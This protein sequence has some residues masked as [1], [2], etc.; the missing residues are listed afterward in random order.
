MH[1][2]LVYEINTRS[3]LKELT[4][5]FG[6]PV[7]LANVPE[8]EC[9]RWEHL[10]F[11]H[12][13]LMGVWTIGP[14][15]GEVA[16]ASGAFAP[17][18]PDS[19][20]EDAEIT[21]SP[22]A[23]AD[24]RIC[25]SL[26][27]EAGLSEFRRQLRG[28]GIKLILDFVPNHVGLDHSWV[29]ERPDFFVQSPGS[30]HGAFSQRTPV[31]DRWLA[32]GRDP[33]FPPW[34]DTVQLDY[35]NPD[36]RSAMK[37]LLLEIAGRCD[38]VRCDMAMLVLS[39]VFARNW[40]AFPEATGKDH[41]AGEFWTEAIPVVRHAHPDFLFLAEA[42]WG[43]E[44]RL[45]SFGFDYTYDKE[46]YD[47]LIRHDPGR[48]QQRLMQLSAHFVE[49]CA[50]FIENHDEPR[51]ASLLSP[52]EHRAA[53]WLILSLPGM[54]LLHDGQL[55]GAR[56]KT[57]VQISR[58]PP[59]TAQAEIQG[60]YEKILGLLKQTAVGQG[61]ATILRPQAAWDGNLTAR[62]FVAVQW[63]ARPPEFDLAVVNLAP[64]H[65]QCRL[66]LG[67]EGR[68]QCDW[69]LSDLLGMEAYQRSGEALVDP[70]LYLDIPGNATQLF[71][72]TPITS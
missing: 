21:G 10:G 23:V 72:F 55:E 51:I 27:G 42:Y 67:L 54:R 35:R 68:A 31:G 52:A 64:Y 13:W 66:P 41:H 3:W 36:V 39:D 2:P 48:V 28:R 32:H 49:A 61:K 30:K 53:A 59:E 57:P 22:Y 7:T 56:V 15:S 18:N 45:Q 19:G 62:N 9:A 46:L 58:R 6:H 17:S 43:L 4:L 20:K 47:D 38:G 69:S 65:S 11:T 63:Q 14:R 40:A 29:K 50:H 25:P 37:A 71:H 8:L 44:T 60:W 70:G 5:R 12:I 34:I 1:Y 33:F 26:G 16:L 24:Y